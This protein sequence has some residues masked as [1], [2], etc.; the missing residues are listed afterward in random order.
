MLSTHHHGSSPDGLVEQVDR[1]LELTRREDARRPVTGHPSRRPWTLPRTRGEDHCPRPNPFEPTRAGEVELSL[2]RPAGH[3]H[4]RADLRSRRCGEIDAAASV[5]RP[6][7][8]PVQVAQPVPG[9]VGVPGDPSCLDLAIDDLDAPC[10]CG[11][12]CS[13]RRQPGGAATDHEHVHLPG[14]PALRI[15]HDPA[16]AT[17]SETSAPQKKP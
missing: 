6:G 2:A 12:E 1:L 15:D 10:S 14:D 9:V 17:R 8:D 3:A 16:P 5:R 11:R 4:S 7:H 13:G